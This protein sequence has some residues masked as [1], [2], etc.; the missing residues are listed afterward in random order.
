[1]VNTIDYSSDLKSKVKMNFKGQAQNKSAQGESECNPE[2]T[3]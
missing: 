1:M 2:K 3:K